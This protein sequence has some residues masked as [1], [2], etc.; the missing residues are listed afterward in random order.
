MT[1]INII[2]E[3]PDHVKVQDGATVHSLVDG[4]TECDRRPVRYTRTEQPVTCQMCLRNGILRDKVDR[5]SEEMARPKPDAKPPK[6]SF[7]RVH[8][9]YEGFDQ[10]P[11]VYFARSWFLTEAGQ[12]LVDKWEE[13]EKERGS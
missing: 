13:E 12:A 8:K 7:P 4:R 11:R 9:R 10:N 6:V 2:I 3:Y 1:A 5:L